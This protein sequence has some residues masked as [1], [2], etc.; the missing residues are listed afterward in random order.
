MKKTP[1]FISIFLCFMLNSNA[2]SYEKNKGKSVDYD[3]NGLTYEGYFVDSGEKAPLVVLIHD[4]D[5]LTDYEV[6]RSEMLAKLGYSVFAV[7]LFGKGIRPTE[8]KDKKQHTGELYKDRTKMR[9][10]MNGSLTEAKKLGANTQNSVAMGYCFGGAAVL[11]WARS[12]ID[13][14]GFATF[15]GG[16]TTPQGQD[17]SNTKG[18]ILILHGTADSAISMDDFKNLALEL[19]IAK[20]PNEMI[21]YSGAEHAFSVF[22]SPRYQKSADEKSWNRFVSFLTEALK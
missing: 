1:L 5:G 9:A 7:D 6:K 15:H 18:E 16:L 11:E 3:V 13:L 19:E 2:A 14:K 20:V 12:G 10:I 8:N 17:Y 4:W 21:S 22:D